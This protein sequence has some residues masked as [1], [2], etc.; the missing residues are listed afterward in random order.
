MLGVGGFE[1]VRMVLSVHV[2]KY[3]VYLALRS[4]LEQGTFRS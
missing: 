2:I 1:M 4:T 3:S